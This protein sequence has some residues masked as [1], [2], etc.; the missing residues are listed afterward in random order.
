M[1]PVSALAPLVLSALWLA[2]CAAVGVHWY[3]EGATVEDLELAQKTCSR[4]AD[5]FRFALRTDGSTLNSDDSF[6]PVRAGSS[7]GGVYRE[8]MERSGWRRV[9]GDPPPRAS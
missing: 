4:Q 8:C 3:K 2:G 6:G 5:D 7:S 1:K 9:R